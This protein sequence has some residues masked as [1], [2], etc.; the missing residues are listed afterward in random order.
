MG[1]A[2]CFD[3]PEV[4]QNV[5]STELGNLGLTPAEGMA[6]IQFVK[7]LSDQ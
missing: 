1:G 5:N 3:P 2:T 7:T 4:A 6:L